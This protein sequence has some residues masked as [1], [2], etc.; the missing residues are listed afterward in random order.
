VRMRTLELASTLSLGEGSVEWWGQEVGSGVAAGRCG[1]GGGRGG[2][3]RARHGGVG[4][5][6]TGRAITPSIMLT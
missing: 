6:K 5:F 3:G 4:S 1:V 2:V